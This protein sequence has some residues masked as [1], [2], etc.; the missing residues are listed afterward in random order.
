MKPV[1]VL[2]WITMVF[3]L[4]I[5]IVLLVNLLHHTDFHKSVTHR[6]VVPEEFPLTF[7]A[8]ASTSISYLQE[9]TVAGL[10]TDIP[11]NNVEIFLIPSFPDITSTNIF[12]NLAAVA[13]NAQALIQM[14]R[15][16]VLGLIM[17]GKVINLKQE[18]F[19]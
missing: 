11:D 9:K 14:E 7:A 8:T 18:I 10:V 17:L 19:L 1:D 6:T 4:I 3:L 15:Y 16:F 12:Y 13:D 5:V 2:L